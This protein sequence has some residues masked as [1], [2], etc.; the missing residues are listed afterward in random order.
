MRP[1]P[2]GLQGLRYPHPSSIP[3]PKSESLGI[4]WGLSHGLLPGSPGR[5]LLHVQLLDSSTPPEPGF[6]QTECLLAPRAGCRGSQTMRSL[7]AA[8]ADTSSSLP[9][10]TL[11]SGQTWR[12]PLPR[13]VALGQPRLR[14]Q[15]LCHLSSLHT[16]DLGPGGVGRQAP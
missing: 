7:N 14:K 4:T 10:P 15:G 1:S 2:L 8:C 11:G 16:M 9:G 13:S 6:S 3:L 5:R 12:R